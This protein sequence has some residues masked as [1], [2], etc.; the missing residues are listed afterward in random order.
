MNKIWLC[1]SIIH[2]KEIF[3]K[4]GEKKKKKKKKKGR[5]ILLR[6]KKKR[7]WDW[8]RESNPSFLD[9]FFGIPTAHLSEQWVKSRDHIFFLIKK[10]QVN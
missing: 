2:L 7:F 10:C 8:E 6:E 1:I 3:L 9:T 4:S 5:N